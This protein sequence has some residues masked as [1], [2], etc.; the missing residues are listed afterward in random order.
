MKL[1]IVPYGI[2]TSMAETIE[3]MDEFLLIVPYG[4]ETINRLK[5]FNVSSFF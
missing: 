3:T 2:E 4:I 1:L 5:V